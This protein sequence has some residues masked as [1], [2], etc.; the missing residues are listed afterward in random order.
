MRVVLRVPLRVNGAPVGARLRMLMVVS[1]IDRGLF[2]ADVELRRG[3]ARTIHALGP[4]SV[5]IDGQAP[6]RRAQ[7]VQRQ[8]GVDERTQDHVAG[9]AREA[10]EVE[11]AHAWTILLCVWSQPPR[12]DEREVPL[13]R[14]DQMIDDLD[15]H[16]AA[17]ADHPRGQRKVVLT[18]CG[19]ARGMVVKEHDG[20]GGRG[21]GFPEHLTWMDDGGVER[22]D[23][24]QL[25]S[26]EPMFG[27]EHHDA[28][29]FD[30]AGA[31]L[32]QQVR[33]EL[34]RGGQPRTF[35]HRSHERAAPELDGRD[36]ARGACGS[37]TRDRA[38]PIDRHARQAVQPAGR[39]R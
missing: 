7:F 14:E 21:R 25:D 3:N 23:G 24:H 39:G 9:G 10:V 13:I 18:G 29:L 6:E 38:K 33:S 5:A 12:L 36:H 19:V 22:P 2:A 16:D 32:R 34:A 37:D 26:D 15:A 17:R 31:V 8:P 20:C 1:V 11:D 35:G 27:V 28:E 30:D 4:Y